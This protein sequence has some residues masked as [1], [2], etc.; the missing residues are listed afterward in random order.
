MY[1]QGLWLRLNLEKYCPHMFW[2][3]YKQGFGSVTFYPADPDL[4]DMDPPE[5]AIEFLMYV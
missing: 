1:I 2:K 4:L 5:N 3:C